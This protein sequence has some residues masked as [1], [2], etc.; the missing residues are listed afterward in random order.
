MLFSFVAFYLLSVI[1][2]CLSSFVLRAV[3]SPKSLHPMNRLSTYEIMRMALFP[4]ANF[5]VACLQFYLAT[6]LILT[7]RK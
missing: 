4:V 5:L 6:T 1:A 3:L 7:N 2:F